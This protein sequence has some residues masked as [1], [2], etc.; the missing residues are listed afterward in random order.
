MNSMVWVFCSDQKRLDT[1]M[2]T[3]KHT[4]AWG[5]ETRLCDWVRILGNHVHHS[6]LALVG[7]CTTS[8]TLVL[9]VWG[10]YLYKRNQRMEPRGDQCDWSWAASF[11]NQSARE[12]CCE[13]EK[14]CKIISANTEEPRKV[15][16]KI[17]HPCLFELCS[18]DSLVASRNSMHMHIVDTGPQ[19]PTLL[20]FSV[21]LGSWLLTC[22]YHD[23]SSLLERKQNRASR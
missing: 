12:E 9:Q 16:C 21:L 15:R 17:S 5:W 18:V 6:I 8:S 11:S 10:S 14:K 22:V 4:V 3:S 7:W 20:V 2:S 1:Y 23:T 13:C 19:R